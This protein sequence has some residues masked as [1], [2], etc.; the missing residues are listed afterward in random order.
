W[1]PNNLETARPKNLKNNTFGPR[2]HRSPGQCPLAPASRPRPGSGP[3]FR[4]G[5]GSS[6][7]GVASLIKKD[8]DSGSR[9]VAIPL[10]ET[11]EAERIEQAV[12][13]LLRRLSGGG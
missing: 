9:V 4:P 5:P 2:H 13:G 10:P 12:G 11:V 7:G 3:S 6:Q 1:P 8:P